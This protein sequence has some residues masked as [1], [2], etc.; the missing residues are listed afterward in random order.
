[1]PHI[2]AGADGDQAVSPAGMV[3]FSDVDRTLSGQA[4]AAVERQFFEQG[5]QLE[6][7]ISAESEAL[8]EAAD[9]PEGPRRRRAPSLLGKVVVLAVVVAGV[10]F[11]GHRWFTGGPGPTPVAVA[12]NPQAR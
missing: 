8:R 2:G 6:A 5:V 1:V 11:I 3:R 12:D 10:S 9:Q 7:A 4:F